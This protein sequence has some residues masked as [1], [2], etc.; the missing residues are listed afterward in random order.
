MQQDRG[1]LVFP[2]PWLLVA[3]LA[4][5]A[6]LPVTMEQVPTILSKAHSSTWAV[7]PTLLSQPEQSPPLPWIVSI[8]TKAL[9]SMLNSFEFDVDIFEFVDTKWKIKTFMFTGFDFIG[10][11]RATV[12]I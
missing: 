1:F 7:V 8:S 2:T 12:I 5:R 3:S 11:T 4:V 6:L 10:E 9:Q